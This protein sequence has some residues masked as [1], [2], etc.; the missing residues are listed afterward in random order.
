[1]TPNAKLYLGAFLLTGASGLIAVGAGSYVAMK[2]TEKR[3]GV[4]ARDVAQSVSTIAQFDEVLMNIRRDPDGEFGRTAAELRERHPFREPAV[5]GALTEE[6]LRKFL[7]VKTRIA[8]VDT[9]MANDMQRSSENSPQMLMKWNFFTRTNRLRTVQA[10]ALEE[11]RLSFE[12][13]HYIEATVMKVMLAEGSGTEEER[14]KWKA[15]LSETLEKANAEIDEQLRNPALTP[16]SRTLLEQTRSE[17]DARE[18]L[19]SVAQSAIDEIGSMPPETIALVN[20]NREELQR[21]MVAGPELG[22]ID[23]MMVIDESGAMPQ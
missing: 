23:L 11:N 2:Q 8:E 3:L 15:E 16:G 14:A 19:T 12:E 4:S 17:V 7:A 21:A 1:M 13:Y 10:Q 5:D 6:S 20:R 18:A 22:M 9:E